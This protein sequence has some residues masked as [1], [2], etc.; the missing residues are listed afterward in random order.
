MNI[1]FLGDSLIEY[2]NWQAALPGHRVYNLG[3]AGESV[4]GLLSRTASIRDACPVADIVFVMSGINNL[5]M[6]DTGFVD[7]YLVLI[8][9]LRAFYE[10][11]EIYVHSLLP[12]AGD[13]ISSDSIVSTNNALKQLADKYGCMYMHIYP[14]FTVPGGMHVSE[15]LMTDGVHLSQAGYDVWIRMIRGIVHP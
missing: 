8:E 5:A 9:R 1:L 6:M 10:E 2:C 3:V 4:Q 13:F 11:A 14:T 15:Y 7:Y 12:V